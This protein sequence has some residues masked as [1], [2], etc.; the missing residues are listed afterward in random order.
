M[1][2]RVPS[3]GGRGSIGGW[4]LTRVLPAAARFWLAWNETA[5]HAGITVALRSC[6]FATDYWMRGAF[7][8]N[9][10]SKM[11]VEKQIAA[12]EA[13]AAAWKAL[14]T[15]DPVGIGTAVLRPYRRRTRANARRLSRSRPSK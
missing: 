3:T 12:I 10:C 11:I 4:P 9:E 15:N 8:A 7:P 2:R 6:K 14:P 1:L 5:F 13:M